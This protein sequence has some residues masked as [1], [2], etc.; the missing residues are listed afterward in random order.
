MLVPR[1]SLYPARKL[2]VGKLKNYSGTKTDLFTFTFF[3]VIGRNDQYLK[4][5]KASFMGARLM[6]VGAMLT[7]TMGAM[8]MVKLGRKAPFL[9]AQCSP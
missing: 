1:G 4:G 2:E 8:L 6:L 3:L 5:R 7:L 9:R